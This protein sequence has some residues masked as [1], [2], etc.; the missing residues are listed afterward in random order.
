MRRQRATGLGRGDK[1]EPITSPSRKSAAEWA[2]HQNP[3]IYD[4]SDRKTKP[5]PDKNADAVA[6]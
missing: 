1:S 4:D 3:S 6:H 5:R 2:E